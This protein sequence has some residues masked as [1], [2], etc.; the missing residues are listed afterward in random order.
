MPDRAHASSKSSPHTARRGGESTTAGVAVASHGTGRSGS[1]EGSGVGGGGGGG[2]GGGAHGGRNGR[3]EGGFAGARPGG[4][5]RRQWPAPSSR[6]NYHARTRPAA[7]PPTSG[8]RGARATYRPSA[9]PEPR[10]P[11]P[12]LLLQ[13]SRRAAVQRVRS[14]REYLVYEA[15]RKA[16]A[17]Q[18]RSMRRTEVVRPPAS[19]RPAAWSLGESA[20]SPP[21]CRLEFAL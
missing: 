12:P 18:G 4:S 19:F 20:P 6:D 11:P 5:S 16:Q 1:H 10:E 7:Q 8:Q 3:A 21:A 13:P 15:P 2:A 14:A 9:R 17:P